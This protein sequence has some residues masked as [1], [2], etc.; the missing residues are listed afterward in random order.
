MG[1]D[2]GE[3]EPVHFHGE[4]DLRPG[5]LRIGPQARFLGHGLRVAGDASAMEGRLDQAALA[6]VLLALADE[7]AVAEEDARALQRP[8]LA[9]GILPGHQDFV[10]KR[11]V[12]EEDEPL[13]EQ[14]EA[15][16]VAAG[17]LEVTE[18]FQRSAEAAMDAANE[19]HFLRAGDG[20]V[21][22]LVHGMKLSG[23]GE[24]AK[25]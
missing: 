5:A 25:D 20:A 2:D 13:V 9:E 8:A 23:C 15:R 21:S 16:R 22:A 14:G 11:G 18:E 12:A 3:G 7:Q 19:R 17:G 10:H 24:K 4:I 6:G 1:G